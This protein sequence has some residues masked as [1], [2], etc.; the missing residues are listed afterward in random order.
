M[1]IALR[2]GAEHRLFIPY[3]NDEV[4]VHYWPHLLLGVVRRF[5]HS[6]YFSRQVMAATNNSKYYRK[7]DRM[8]DLILL[9]QQSLRPGDETKYSLSIR[10]TVWCHICNCL[11][12]FKLLANYQVREEVRRSQKKSTAVVRK[13]LKNFTKISF[14]CKFHIELSGT[15]GTQGIKF[16]PMN[17]LVLQ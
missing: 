6:P 1:M 13:G 5:L 4:N 2:P 10:M 8:K 7:L 12:E 17:Q 11:N 14:W 9:F 15:S 3:Q 16:H